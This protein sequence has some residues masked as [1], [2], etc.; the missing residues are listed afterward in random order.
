LLADDSFADK[1]DASPNIMAFKNGII[2][3][4]TKLFRKGI[5]SADFITETI[6]Y[7]YTPSNFKKK[8]FLKGVLK[9]I[10]NNND[11]H[12]EYYLSIIGYSFI[13]MA[14]LEKSIYKA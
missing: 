14:H 5:L 3:L 11:E 4:K 1:L 12:L 13:G 8:E 6:P 7:D 10:L 9:K 2:D